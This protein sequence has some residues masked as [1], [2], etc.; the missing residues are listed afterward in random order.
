MTNLGEQAKSG[1]QPPADGGGQVADMKK[2]E[3]ENPASGKLGLPGG[4]NNGST[5]LWYTA[6]DVILGSSVI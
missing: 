4:I 2:S 6:A 3:L 5:A 1:S